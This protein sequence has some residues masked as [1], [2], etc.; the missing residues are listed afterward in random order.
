[1]I[2]RYFAILTAAV[3]LFGSFRAYA[4]AD[5]RAEANAA[6]HKAVEA[7]LVSNEV[8]ATLVSLEQAGGAGVS[9]TGAQG[10]GNGAAGAG[11][12][13]P[14]ASG[15]RQERYAELG[16]FRLTSYCGCRICNGRWTGHPTALG[17]DYQEGRTIAVDKRVIPLGSIVEIF[18]PGHG[19]QRFRAEDTGSAIK[20]NRIDVYVSEHSRCYTPEY[21]TTAAVRLVY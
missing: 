8:S 1:M 12:A 13:A 3:L 14:A 6:E 11:S 7:T 19:W 16:N 17:T 18:I 5:E 20:G 4:A 2:R 10:A 15:L 9:R 21:N